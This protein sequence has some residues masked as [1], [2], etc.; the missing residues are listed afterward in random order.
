VS[1]VI[2]AMDPAILHMATDL[3]TG[4]AGR[5]HSGIAKIS[6]PQTY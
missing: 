2:L 1:V 3:R 4:T 6:E 5:R